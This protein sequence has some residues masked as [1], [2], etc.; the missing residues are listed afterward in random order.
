MPPKGTFPSSQSNRDRNL[1]HPQHS[2]IPLPL[3]LLW[4]IQ[5]CSLPWLW[6]QLRPRTSPSR[7]LRPRTPPSRQ[8][9]GEQ[10]FI[11]FN[12]I[13]LIGPP[14]LLLTLCTRMV[15]QN[16]DAKLFPPS[17]CLVSLQSCSS[18]QTPGMSHLMV[19]RDYQEP[20][21]TGKKSKCK[22]LTDN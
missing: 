12:V 8:L 11:T 18:G 14:N 2:T 1:H 16:Q 6:R 19:S 21:L 10:D 13:Y 3:D 22:H 15:H 5:T 17:L 9:S 7:Q 4:T 20:D